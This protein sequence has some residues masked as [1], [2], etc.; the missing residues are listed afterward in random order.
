MVKILLI[1][2]ELIIAEDVKR[3]LAK[4]GYH[5]IGTAMDYDE[6]LTILEQETPDL[7]LLDINLNGKKDG[8][9]LA[10]T[11]NAKYKIP[12]V[13]TTSY[14]DSATLARAKATNPINYLVKPFKEEQLFTAIELALYKLAETHEKTINE[15]KND[16]ALIIK[17]ALFIKDKF[18]YTKL[19]INDILWIKSDGNYLEIQTTNK[20]ELIR[21]TLTNFIEKLNSDTFFKTHKSYIVNLDYLTKLETHSVTIVDKQ[22]PISKN[23]YEELLKKLNIV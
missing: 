7:I 18:K 6:A 22:V 2:D 11:I 14:S 12:F 15:P 4:M 1:E 19:N 16:E 21:A 17:D 3:M 9:D 5:I 8:I 13:Y 10:N 20:E 23:Y